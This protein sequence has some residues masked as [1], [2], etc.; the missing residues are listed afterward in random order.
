MHL[1]VFIST[2]FNAVMLFGVAVVTSEHIRALRPFSGDNTARVKRF[3][4]FGV[5]VFVLN[6]A[7]AIFS[8]FAAMSDTLEHWPS[9]IV[10]LYAYIACLSTVIGVHWISTSREVLYDNRLAKELNEEHT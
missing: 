9:D 3:V 2:S 6:F 1:V 4:R 8:L 5:A 7:L 10:L